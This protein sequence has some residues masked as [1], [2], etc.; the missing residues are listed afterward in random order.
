MC[1]AAISAMAQM[2]STMN[3]VGNSDFYLPAMKEQSL[4]K[5]VK[6]IVTV[7]MGET[8]QSITVPE[9][10]YPAMNMTIP[11]FTIPELTYTMTGSP[12]TGDM[13]FEWSSNSFTTTT[14]DAAG[15]EKTVTG[16]AL[17][18]K[19]THADGTLTLEVTFNYGK[20]PMAITYEAETYYTV[21]DNKWQLAGRGTMANPYRIFDDEDF[22]NM[23]KNYSTDND[24][25]GE[26]FLMMNDVDFGGTAEKPAQLPAIAKDGSLQIANI[27]TGFNGFFEGDNH[28][29]SGIYHTNNANDAAGKYNALFSFVGKNGRINDVT[30]TE[31]NHITGYN[32]LGTI[33]SINMGTVSGC[34]NDADVTAANAFAGG[35]CGFLAQGT[36]K[37]DNCTNFGTVKAMTYAAGI[38]GGAVSTSAVTEYL[39]EV[40][41]CLNH[42]FVS[43]V[44]GVG[45]AGIAGSY[46]G[47]VRDC[48]NTGVIN[49]SEGTG[50]TKQNTAGIVSGATK[51][52]VIENCI[53]QGEI[54]GGNNVAGIVANIMKGDNAAVNI[55]GCSNSGKVH[56]AGQYVAGIAATTARAAGLV[57]LSNCKALA[58]GEVTADGTETLL[59]NL[60]G[61]EAI[62]FGEGNTIDSTLK[63]LNLD[64]SS[65]GVK[66][67]KG[68]EA[69]ENAA[70]NG[71]FLKN[72]RI[73]IV[74][75]GVEYNAVG[76]RY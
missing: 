37:I 8:T 45:S 65:T 23:A 7:T 28:Q 20:M 43:T 50:K 55:S 64:P 73:V 61:N 62:T 40:S 4:T 19:Y 46:S 63:H 54:L 59:G 9:M 75:N 30:F 68:V 2:H 67:V 60:R 52:V 38:V 34:R 10:Y 35:I 24:G 32:Y 22:Y 48:R 39:Y 6:D 71:T 17:K 29:I 3:F 41:E 49:D 66:G 47:A 16:T 56:G 74:K 13:A 27:S 72:G 1:V 31:N 53:N 33:A 36:G 25:T 21:M 18:A 70:V 11:S 57:T 5:N 44:N 14:K 15:A 76:V 26:Y 12:A 58:G 42:G 69:A 51:A